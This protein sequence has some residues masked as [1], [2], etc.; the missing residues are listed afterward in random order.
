MTEG[1]LNE[2]YLIL[3]SDAEIEEASKRYGIE[4]SLP[5]FKV[6]GLRGWDDFLVSDD[7]GT[8]YSVPTVPLE[9][10]YLKEATVPERS[11]L[12]SDSRLKEKIKW[13]LKPLVFG[14]NA[15]E[16][17]NLTWVSHEQH[18]GLVVWWNNQY[19]TL[20]TQQTKDA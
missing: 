15:N 1:W 4:Q 14:G 3:F 20:K 18:A 11:S 7:V 12:K 8:T 10:Q 19:R 5:G 2:D 13:Y 6:L 16:Q 17:A 9:Q